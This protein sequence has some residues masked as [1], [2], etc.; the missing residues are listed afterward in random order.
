M[1]IATLE[2]L[3]KLLENIGRGKD[4]GVLSFLFGKKTNTQP[5]AYVTLSTSD[6]FDYYNPK[7]FKTL[8]SR[9]DISSLNRYFDTS[10][11]VTVKGRLICK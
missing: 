6:E 1:T 4:M 11:L 3:A 10:G 7:Y 2:S 5:N 9:P 8:E